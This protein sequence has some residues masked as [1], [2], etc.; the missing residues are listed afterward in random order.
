MASPSPTIGELAR[1]LHERGDASLDIDLP[2]NAT[3]DLEGQPGVQINGAKLRFASLADLNRFVVGDVQRE[4]GADGITNAERLFGAAK[5]LQRHEISHPDRASGRL[6]A[7]A[8]AGGTDVLQLAAHAVGDHI[9]V[10]DALHAI[11]NM[12]LHC[13]T[14]PL[15][16]LIALNDAQHELT[17]GDMA[18]NVFFG[19]LQQWLVSHVAI[20]QALLAELLNEPQESRATL[21]GTAWMGWFASE[22][23]TAAQ[24]LLQAVDRRERPLPAVTTWIAGRMLQHVSLPQELAHELDT[25]VLCRLASMERTERNAALEAATGLLHLRRSFDDELKRLAGARDQDALGYIATAIVREDDELRAANLFFEWLAPCKHLGEAYKG[26]LDQL[27]FALSRLLHATPVERD[28]TLTF[29]LD[30]IEAQPFE[31]PNDRRFAELFNLSAANVLNSPPLLSRVVTQWLLSDSKAP[32]AAIAGLLSGVRNYERVELSF[33]A[34]LLDGV[35]DS[36]LLYLARRLLGYIIDSEHLLSLA[37]SLLSVSQ[38]QRRVFPMMRSLLGDEIG[39]DYP[40]TTIRR[41]QI[42]EHAVDPAASA[43]FAE[44]RERLEADMARLEALPRLKELVPPPALRRTFHKARA[45]QM[46]RAMADAQSKSI[47]QQLVTTV[48]LKGGNRSFQYLPEMLGYTEPMQ[49]KPMSVSFEMPRR[50]ALDP[51]GNAYRMHSNRSAE[52]GDT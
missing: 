9:C 43:L 48:H 11:E 12:L 25:V 24:S 16:S 22:P 37:L 30:W 44:I 40:G 45:K 34:Q 39:Y 13:D 23:A 21:T 46:A 7:A 19:K 29:L 18:A 38:A 1:A 15:H 27:D 8:Q 49:L 17:H 51:V 32:A 33:D 10:F 41:L 52:R 36:D 3:I 31:G 20:A 5:A 28:A 6:L 50:E 14:L 35:P 47:L 42:A 26:A 2:A 4:L